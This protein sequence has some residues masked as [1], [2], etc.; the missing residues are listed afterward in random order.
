MNLGHSTWG[1]WLSHW[2]IIILQHRQ[3][4]TLLIE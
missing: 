1:I 2:N 4:W 3:R